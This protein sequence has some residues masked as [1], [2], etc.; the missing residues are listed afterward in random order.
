[1]LLIKNGD[2]INPVSMKQEKCDVLIAEGII[3]K[4]GN[5]SLQDF[6]EENTKIIDAKGLKVGPGLVDIH[7][8]FREPGFTDKED[9]DTGAK[10][11]AKGGFTT[12][13][14]MANTKPAVDNIETLQYVLH[15]GKSTLIRVESCATI[16]NGMQGNNVTDMSSLKANGA[17]GFTD[18]GVPI[19]KEETLREALKMA[20]EL[21]VPISLHE[22]NPD[23]II[24]NGV[25]R[26]KASD[27]F[28]IGGSDREAEISMIRR[29]VKIALEIGAQLNIQHISTKEGVDLIRQGRKLCSN[30]HAEATPHHFS[31][32]EEDTIEHG[33]LAKMNP[34]LRTE[35]D[36]LAIIEGLRDG[37]IEF[38]A[39]DHAP[40]MAKEKEQDITAAP[41]GIIG[42]ETAFGLA[43]TN[44][45]KP[46][47][48][49]LPELFQ[50]MSYLPSKFY[51]L[52]TGIL[53]EGAPADII[54]FDDQ[55]E[56]TYQEEEIVSKSKNSPFIGKKLYG[57][58]DY[59]ICDGKIIYERKK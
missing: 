25:N 10:A 36:R 6:A 13:V 50:K 19:L 29:D 40:H 56:Y 23:Y 48:L 59:T 26:G 27:H 33:T 34:P 2:V 55:E 16:T 24:N 7:V 1:M 52:N 43:I 8:H 53:K 35:E 44:L 38:I 22:E 32:T 46:G 14:L 11:A 41:S 42:L 30:I 15:K 21:N 31:M 51:H 9:I 17:A 58:I 47:Y 37:T 4:I 3:K 45:V 20:K 54:L 28:G 39:T 49:S 18:D 12:V 5:I 57:R